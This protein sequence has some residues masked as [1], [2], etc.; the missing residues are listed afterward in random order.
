MLRA[1]KGQQSVILVLLLDLSGAFDTVDHS[2]LLTPLSQKFGIKIAALRVRVRV[3][4]G[5]RVRVI[6]RG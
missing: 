1:F 4:V 3:R 2:I 5:V 6:V